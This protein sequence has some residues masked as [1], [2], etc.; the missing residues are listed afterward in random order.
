MPSHP[1]LTAEQIKA[2]VQWIL[3]NAAARNSIYYNGTSGILQFPEN[4]KGVYQ[5]TASFTDHGIPGAPAKHL[6]GTDRITLK[7]E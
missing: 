5:L 6:K 3:K 2:T 4:K 7:L 1:E